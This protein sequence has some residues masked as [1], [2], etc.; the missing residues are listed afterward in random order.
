MRKESMHFSRLI[1]LGILVLLSVACS[2]KHA[3]NQT[4]SRAESTRAKQTEPVKVL[5][6]RHDSSDVALMGAAFLDAIENAARKVPPNAPGGPV[7]LST[8]D[9]LKLEEEK[10]LVVWNSTLEKK[11]TPK[12]EQWKWN[13]KDFDFLITWEVNSKEQAKYF[14]LD[15]LKIAVT[16]TWKVSKVSDPNVTKSWTYNFT[17][18]GGAEI[19]AYEKTSAEQVEKVIAPLRGPV[20]KQIT[21]FV[22]T[23]RSSATN[24]K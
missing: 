2:S 20:L 12:P 22:R 19:S 5:L 15:P 24:P 9:E 6:R 17:L 18:D 8:G 3:G 4:E 14:I 7:L 23:N 13:A 10:S 11:P 16:E 21:D 1:I